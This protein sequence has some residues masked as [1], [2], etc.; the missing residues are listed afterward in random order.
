MLLHH[1]WLD[2]AHVVFRFIT[3]TSWLAQW[4]L[5]SPESR[6]FTQRFDHNNF[7]DYTPTGK[8]YQ[9]FLLLFSSRFGPGGVSP[10]A[11]CQ[12][13]LVDL[14]LEHVELIGLYNSKRSDLLPKLGFSW[15]KPS[16]ARW[17]RPNAMIRN[18]PRP[19]AILS[20]IHLASV[21]GTIKPLI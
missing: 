10:N 20:Q 19:L 15:L 21:D 12:W 14:R 3:V 13:K 7:N 8:F 17:W 11:H 4:R 6:L 16:M 5:K 18:S 9:M 2:M 1:Q